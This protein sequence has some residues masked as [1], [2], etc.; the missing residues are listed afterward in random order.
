MSKRTLHTY[1]SSSSSGNA[2]PIPTPNENTGQLKK[3][4]VEFRHTD[5]IGDPGNRKPI[6][7]YAPEIRDQVK[8]AYALGGPTQPSNH[9]FPCKWQ[10]GE[11]RSFQKT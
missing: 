1:Y 4:R 5:I 9:T 10:S 2:T 3:P 8:R 6:D 11:W 7:E